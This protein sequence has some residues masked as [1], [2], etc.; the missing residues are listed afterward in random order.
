MC[1]LAA[2]YFIAYLTSGLAK[3]RDTGDGLVQDGS[4]KADK[5]SESLH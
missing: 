4:R 2:A 3:L 5:R 1:G